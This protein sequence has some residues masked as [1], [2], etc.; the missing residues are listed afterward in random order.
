MIRVRYR[1]QT[2]DLFQ[3]ETFGDNEYEN[4]QRRFGEAIQH[5]AQVEIVFFDH[6]DDRMDLVVLDRQGLD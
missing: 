6:E 2:G 1:R 3:E 5:W 4:A